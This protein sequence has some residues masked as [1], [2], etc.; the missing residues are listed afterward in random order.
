MITDDDHYENDY[1]NDDDEAADAG[2]GI[3]MYFH[4]PSNARCPSIT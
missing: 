3:C 2:S 1:D 4:H